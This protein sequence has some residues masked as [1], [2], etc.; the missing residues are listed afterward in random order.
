MRKRFGSFLLYVTHTCK[1]L[2][3]GLLQVHSTQL[4]QPTVAIQKEIT[5]KLFFQRRI[6]LL[7]QYNAHRH[8]HN[9]VAGELLQE[10]NQHGR[11]MRPHRKRIL[12]SVP[13]LALGDPTEN[14]EIRPLPAIGQ[15]LRICKPN[16][17][18]LPG[19]IA[20]ALKACAQAQFCIGHTNG[21]SDKKLNQR[22]HLNVYSNAHYSNDFT[23][24]SIV[25]AE[26]GSLPHFEEQR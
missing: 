10:G 12:H 11:T 21:C 23:K 17:Q 24:M 20:A 2:R 22:E 7:P 15:Q 5:K 19:A 4:P 18:N 1:R 16:A 6:S 13:Q 25:S 26:L 9:I 3:R 14:R 8:K